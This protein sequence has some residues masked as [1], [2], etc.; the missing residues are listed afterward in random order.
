MSA[1][2]ASAP[3]PDASDPRPHLK[4]ALAVFR[5][6]VARGEQMTAKELEAYSATAIA[7]QALSVGPQPKTQENNGE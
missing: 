4:A 2:A 6:K 3:T 7:A 1:I 5:A